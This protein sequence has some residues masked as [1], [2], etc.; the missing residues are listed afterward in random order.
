[1]RI[2]SRGI[3]PVP[4][5]ERHGRSRSLFTLWFAANL[6]IPPWFL[7]VL[8]YTF[9]LGLFWSLATVLIGNL[10]GAALVGLPSAM[11]PAS[12]LPQLAISRY[13]FGRFGVYLPAALNWLSCLGW[14]AVNSLLGGE[15]LA[16][17]LHLP[18]AAGIVLIGILQL[19]IAAVG[20]DMVHAVERWVSVLLAL[21]FAFFTWRAAVLGLGV[22]SHGGFAWA[23]FALGIAMI[24]SYV[25]SWAPYAS[26]Y[27]RYLPAGT[28]RG[29]VFGWTFLG[30]LLSCLWVE[31]LGVALASR[32]RL[33][34]AVPLLHQAA[35]GLS[36]FV[37][38]AGIL[39]TLTANLLNIYT[40]ATSLLALGIRLPRATAA[41][42]VGVLGT[43]LALLGMRGFSGDYESFLL[44]L[45]YW[46]APWLGVALAQRATPRAP[47]A[48][49]VGFWAFIIGFAASVPFMSQSL[50]TGPAA[51]AMGGADIAYYVGGLVAATLY[52]LLR[53]GSRSAR[54]P[55]VPQ[56][57]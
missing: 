23:P 49:E 5:S 47:Q 44:L 31:V 41:M 45:S 30:S 8:L 56:R 43:V 6:G 11:G 14:F 21:T 18:E 25:F 26:D 15:L 57:A 40:G 42:A 39:G 2:E 54:G 20:H 3:E 34:D 17:L 50:F 9:G 13:G 12:G 37:F 53:R 29:A 48:I 7:G 51:R 27:S 22:P 33:F 4:A 46:I 1:L 52:L 10:I 24:A 19:V 32:F 35:G 16:S 55:A 28:A 38:A 36:V